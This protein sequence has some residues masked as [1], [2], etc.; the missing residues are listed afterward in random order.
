MLQKDRYKRLL[1]TAEMQPG[2]TGVTCTDGA[3]GLTET[4]M[5][6]LIVTVPAQNRL[7]RVSVTL[8]VLATLSQLFGLLSPKSS[9]KMLPG[10]T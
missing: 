4:V 6:S 7:F 5:E 3:N 1:D 9:C 10:G 2:R 8:A